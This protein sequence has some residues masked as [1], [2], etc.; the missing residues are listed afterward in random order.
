[1]SITLTDEEHAKLRKFAG[2]LGSQFDG[3]RLNAL[4]FIQRMADAKKVRV[5]ELLL[6]RMVTVVKSA[7]QEPPRR[8]P[9]RQEPPRQEKPK[10][11]YREQMKRCVSHHDNVK[12]FMTAWERSFAEDMAKSTWAAPTE[13]QQIYVDRIL[14]KSKKFGG[15]F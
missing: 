15:E 4:G 6:A 3:E 12:P 7:P 1:M 9:P 10:S 11:D 5:D 14:E 13:K 2:M 8:E